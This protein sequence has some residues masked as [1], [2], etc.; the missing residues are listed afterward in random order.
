MQNLRQLPGIRHQFDVVAAFLEQAF[1]VSGL[2]IINTD[3]AAGNMRGQGQHRYA[4]AMGVE[5]AIDQMQVAWPATAGAYRQF[6]GQMGFGTGGKR[7]GLFVAHMDPLDLFLA[8]QGIGKAVEGIA[9]HAKHT[10]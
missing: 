4:A 9:H 2:E 1:G 10:L 6:T 5:Q 3:F 8:A 7:G